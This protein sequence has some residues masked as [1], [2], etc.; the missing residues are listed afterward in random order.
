[1][2]PPENVLPG[3][4]SGAIAARLFNPLYRFRV[5]LRSFFNKFYRV[6]TITLFNQWK[7]AERL[8]ATRSAHLTTPK[9][10]ELFYIFLS[11]DVIGQLA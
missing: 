10:S 5:Q 7:F 3:A 1:L 6:C 11:Y 4:A 9:L 8:L 2:R